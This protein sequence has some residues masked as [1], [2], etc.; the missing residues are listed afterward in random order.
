MKKFFLALIFW[1]LQS[2]STASPSGPVIP[3]TDQQRLLDISQSSRWHRLIHYESGW[4]QSSLV[5]QVDDGDFFLAATGKTD[6]MAE[7]EATLS[8]FYLPVKDANQHAI[9]RYPARWDYLRTSLALPAGPLT[10]QQCPELKKWLDILNPHSVSLIFASSYLNSPSSMFGHTFLR[11]DPEDVEEG[12]SWLSYAVNFGA[13]INNQ[14]NSILYAYRG[15]F[16]GYPGFF[17]VIPYYE[18]INV[19][20]RL[21]NRDLWEYDLNLTTAETQALVW[22]LWELRNIDFD[23]YFFDENCSYRLL[24]LLEVARPGISLRE[25]FGTRAIPI[26]TVRAVKDAG[27]VTSTHYRPSAATRI[28]HQIEQLSPAHQKLAWQLAHRQITL[29]DDSLVALPEAQRAPVIQLAYQ[30]V[31]YLQLHRPRDTD[32]ANFSRQL[33]VALSKLPSEPGQPETPSVSPELSHGTLL[34]GLSGGSWEDDG[35]ADLRLRMSYHDL[36]DNTAGYLKGAAINIG[37]LKLRKFEQ[38]S[39]QLEL[40]NFI[41]I[42]SHSP[43]SQF[44]SPLTWRVSAGFER[45]YGAGDDALTPRIKGGAG[46]SYELGER[47]IYYALATARTEY[48]SLLEDNL[49]LGAGATAGTLLFFPFG[50]LQLEVDYHSFVDGEERHSAQ[51]IQNIPVSRNNALR[52]RATHTSQLGFSADEFSLEFRHYY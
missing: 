44:F 46:V 24:E 52:L 36:T 28:E 4:N 30:H 21:E 35:F 43:R 6:P 45:F 47:V 17:S 41:D 20:S 12:S 18:K 33:L 31:R 1:Q 3:D 42:N 38:Q 2:L 19:Y 13:E 51:L 49:A 50:T 7:L 9:C 29:Q 26:D 40:L 32:T 15:L 8:A 5:S 14:D 10:T 16:G 34:A 25:D 48:N 11:V 22:H 39:A 27:L 37:E 23:Y